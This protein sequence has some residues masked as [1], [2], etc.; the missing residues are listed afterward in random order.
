[1]LKVLFKT[2]LYRCFYRWGYP[3]LLPFSYTFSVT[4]KCNSRC[5]TCGVWER[6]AEDLTLEEFKKLFSSLGSS[7]Y[8]VTLSGGE[9]FLRPDIAELVKALYDTCHPGVINIPTNAIL[10]ELIPKKVAEIAG[11]CK[12][13]DLIINV[14]LD[15]INEKHDEI[16]GVRDNYKKAMKTYAELKK[17]D[18]PNLTV[19]IHTVISKFNI[20]R[21][22]EIFEEL[23]K[24]GPDS[25]VTEIAEKREE[26]LT[27]KADITPEKGDYKTAVEFIIRETEKKQYKGAG[28]LTKLLRR[29]YYSLV[30]RML[31]EKKQV[32]PCYAGVTTAHVAADGKVWFCCMKSEPVGELRD[33]EIGYDLKKIWFTQKAKALRNAIKK[34]RCYCPMANMAY[35]NML[36]SPVTIA[37]LAF[38]YIF[39]MLK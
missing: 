26:L 10:S 21:I 2:I 25:Y 35:T 19:G 4:F 30:I 32:L 9:P 11:Y 18:L 14:S 6:K 29:E 28:R 20:G 5:R 37:R 1:M 31:E 33:K 34:E 38:K 17:L 7:P 39:G 36:M 13:S 24:L 22:K 23:S 16:R 8:W 15:D 27:M 3:K 12:Q